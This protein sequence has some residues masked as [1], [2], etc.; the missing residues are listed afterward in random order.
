MPAEIAM[1]QPLDYGGWRFCQSDCDRTGDGRTVSMLSAV[2]DPGEFLKYLGCTMTCLGMF[3]VY[4]GRGFAFLA[5][6]WTWF[7]RATGKPDLA[8]R[9]M[10]T[11][12]LALLPLAFWATAAGAA[13]GGAAALD[14]L[15]W[16]ALPVQEGGRAKPLDTLARETLRALGNA[17]SLTDPQTQ[18]KLDPTAAYL[19]LLLTGQGWERPASPQPGR[20]RGLSGLSGPVRRASPRASVC[21]APVRRRGLSC[22]PGP[23]FRAPAR[24]LGPRTPVA[25]R[26]G[27]AAHRVGPAGGPE[28][29]F[30]S[31]PGP[32]GD[33]RSPHRRK[34]PLPAPGPRS[35]GRQAGETRLAGSQGPGAVGAVRGV[36]GAPPRRDAVGPAAGRQHV[37]R[38]D[39]RC[40]PHR[41]RLGRQN[42]SDRTDPPGARRN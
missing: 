6:P 41:H 35:P 33:H 16:Q 4:Y 13:P 34:E 40:P 29:Y 11:G 39:F 9:K 17:S 36:P 12:L 18:E 23:V 38:V 32:G 42:G 37:A 14:W 27:G 22:L 25:G 7:R 1:N 31:R 8:R 15:P 19:V 5:A 20:R 2:S 24:R 26:L 30:L 3:V 21:C 10:T 28:A